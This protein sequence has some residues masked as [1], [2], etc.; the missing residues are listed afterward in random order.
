MPIGHTDTATINARRP[1]SERMKDCLSLLEQHGV[2]EHAHLKTSAQNSMRG[3]VDRGLVEFFMIDATRG[4]YR[5]PKS[6]TANK[7]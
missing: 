1:L 5:L 3:L 4:G 7:D 2:I 6:S